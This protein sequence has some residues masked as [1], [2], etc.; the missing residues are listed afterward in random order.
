ME[1]QFKHFIRKQRVKLHFIRKQ[2]VT[3]HKC[4]K[5]ELTRTVRGVWRGGE[6]GD[7]VGPD[8]YKYF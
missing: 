7:L 2:M 8:V 6:Q 1:G 3:N 5:D 4:G